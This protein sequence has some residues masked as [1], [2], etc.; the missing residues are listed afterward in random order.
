MV[1]NKA[2]LRSRSAESLPQLEARYPRPWACS[3]RCSSR[4]SCSRRRAFARWASTLCRVTPS[5]RSSQARRV[6]TDSRSTDGDTPPNAAPP[7]SFCVPPSPPWPPAALVP[8]ESRLPPVKPLE[9]S[10]EKRPPR[11][12]PMVW[13]SRPPL[14]LWRSLSSGAL[15]SEEGGQ[16]GRVPSGIWTN[17]GCP[18]RPVAELRAFVLGASADERSTI[19]P[20]APPELLGAKLPGPAVAPNN[21]LM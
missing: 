11:P 9:K 10:P 18:P 13:P 20:L 4:P 8:A 7:A 3:L 21:C 12:S 1:A 6:A 15:L 17:Q 16:V 14:T 5:S 2:A 19:C